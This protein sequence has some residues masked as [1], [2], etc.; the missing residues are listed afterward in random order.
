ME[1]RR[2]FGGVVALQ[3]LKIPVPG[4]VDIVYRGQRALILDGCLSEPFLQRVEALFDRLPRPGYQWE[5]IK[6]LQ[7]APSVLWPK[8]TKK[9]KDYALF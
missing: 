6:V 5:T 2:V 1:F 8:G 4:H 9:P 7:S 3:L